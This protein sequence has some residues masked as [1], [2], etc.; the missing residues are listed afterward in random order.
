MTNDEYSADW[1]L[2][3]VIRVDLDDDEDD[4]PDDADADG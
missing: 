3:D 4:E 2:G 1:E